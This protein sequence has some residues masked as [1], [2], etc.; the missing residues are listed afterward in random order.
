VGGPNPIRGVR[1]PFQGFGPY[2]WGSWT[3]LGGPDCI[4][5]GLA[6]SHGGPDSLLMSW[7]ISLSLDTWRPRTL[8]CGGLLLAQSSRP[9]LERVMAWSH[10]QLFYHATKDSHVGTASLYSSKGY[11]SFRVTV[12]LS[13]SSFGICWGLVLKCYELRTR[14]H[15]KK[16]MVNALCPSK[17]YF[18]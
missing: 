9:R 1:I 18:L 11:P 12:L 16:L 13:N 14:Q 6:L 4:S 5:R 7:S 17:H 10:V 15:R 3:K 8:L 2:T